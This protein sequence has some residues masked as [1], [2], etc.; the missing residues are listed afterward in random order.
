MPTVLI[1]GCNRGLGLEFLKQYL[2]EG[3]HVLGCCRNPAA[4]PLSNAEPALSLHRLDV[5]DFPAMGAL[6]KA[7]PDVTVDLLINNAGVMGDQSPLGRTDY[8]AFHST[9]KI[10]TLAPLRMT[11][12]FLPH[13]ERSHSPVV[14]HV[15]SKM[16]SI[17]ANESGGCYPYRVSKAAL[18][19]VN[20]NLSLD[21]RGR[22]I[23][24]VLHPGW[25]ST[26][27]GGSSAPVSPQ[28]SVVGM[29]RVIAGLSEADTGAFFNFD[30]TRLPW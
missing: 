21:L 11:E 14:V 24:V 15:T 23:C 27:M 10:N 6:A 13:L 22:V 8:D 16:G 25:V 19:M 18:N 30:G 26:D 28:Q 2:A 12:C 9:L 4:H 20:G 29:R 5:T 17:A 1:T 7:L 3:W